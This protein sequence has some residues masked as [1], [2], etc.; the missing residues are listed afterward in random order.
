M[1]QASSPPVNFWGSTPD[2]EEFYA[3]AGVRNTKAFVDTPYGRL[4]TQSWHPLSETS[5]PRALVFFTH[6]YASD[7]SWMFQSIPITFAQW[8]YATFA[9]DLLGHGQ[10]DGLPGYIEDIQTTASAALF[11]YKSVRDGPE[12]GPEY[13]QKKKFL[14]GESMGGGLTFLMLLQDPQGWDGAIFSAP[15]LSVPEPARP[16]GLRLLAY[17]LLLGYAE[18]WP[19][20]PQNNIQGNVFH[21]QEKAKIIRMNPRRYK[22]PARVGTMRQLMVL[23]DI[24]EKRCGE[25]LTPFLVLHGTGDTCTAHE[26]SQ[27]LYDKAKSSDKTIKLYDGFYHSLLQAELKEN[28]ERVYMDIHAWIDARTSVPQ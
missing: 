25:V 4:F 27:M 16:S 2:A 14:F 22:L 23:C 26:G 10:S 17:G 8:G 9:A 19:V 12:Y 3:A 21:D 7:T 18:T 11:F 6:G 5:S 13:A 24:F 20:M 15:F 28:S 1:E